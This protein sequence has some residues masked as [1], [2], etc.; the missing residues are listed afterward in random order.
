M[1][2]LSIYERRRVAVATCITL[3][4]LPA[5]WWA[6]RDQPIAAPSVA[7]ADT[8]SGLAAGILTPQAVV[9]PADSPPGF[10]SGPGQDVAPVAAEPVGPAAEETFTRSGLGTFKTFPDL[11]ERLCEVS[12]LPD[13]ARITVENTDNGQRVEC[14]VNRTRLP[15]DQLIILDASLFVELSDLAEAPIPVRIRW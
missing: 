4:A 3:V 14:F 2:K 6:K 9:A 7:A 12:F 10:L 5:L 11:S 15:S 8:G 13:G 1:A